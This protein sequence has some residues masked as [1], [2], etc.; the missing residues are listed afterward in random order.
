M[1]ARKPSPIFKHYNCSASRRICHTKNAIAMLFL[2]IIDVYIS[3]QKRH[4]GMSYGIRKHERN[5]IL[6]LFPCL[7]ET[8]WLNHGSHQ[9]V[10]SLLQPRI[11]KVDYDQARKGEDVWVPTF[12]D[13]GIVRIIVGI[14]LLA[15]FFPTPAIDSPLLPL[16][17]AYKYSLK[18]KEKALLA[19]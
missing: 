9:W 15:S 4:R 2:P 5:T 17:N 13:V 3:S 6:C 14:P 8:L 11:P 1:L 18:K 10:L 19:C 7:V 16:F 12:F